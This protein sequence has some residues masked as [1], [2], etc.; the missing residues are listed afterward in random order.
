MEL[1]KSENLA[2]NG[3]KIL[4]GKSILL[5]ITGSIAAYKA[6][7][8]IRLLEGLGA[9]IT[10]VMTESAQKFITPL[11][12]KVISRNPVYH[13][14]FN[15]DREI[16]HLSLSERNNLILIAPATA[17]IIAKIAHG[18]ADDLLSSLILASKKE[19]IIAPAMDSEMWENPIMCRN[20]SILKETG[21]KVIPPGR[22]ELAS[23]KKGMGRLAEEERIVRTVT[24]T[25]LVRDNLKGKLVLI[26]AGPT[27]EPIDPVRFISSRSSGKMGYAL[28]EAA[29][30]RGAEVILITGP[31]AISPPEGTKTI[32]IRKAEEMREKVRRHLSEANI[33]I[34]A[35]AVSDYRPVEEVSHKIK[36]ERDEIDLRLKKTPDILKEITRE[37][38][39]QIV[40]GFAAET[41]NLM[42]NA[43]SKLKEKDLDIIVANDVT[44]EGSG[45][46]SNTN[47]VKIIDRDGRVTNLQKMSK[48]KI[49]DKIMDMIIRM[50]V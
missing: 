41:D 28:A 20:I 29:R 9:E 14:M 39:R 10:V 2:G 15:T 6:V 36:K 24:D 48:I 34:M 26:T 37:K 21:I 4:K 22:G 31:V 45:F 49:A 42:K 23:G 18:I 33:V 43:L 5:G 17:N 50:S 47:I 7:N 8:I 27:Q 19:I 30:N 25:L 38:G 35:A 32:K 11:T 40:V 44:I 46:G 12:L 1:E 3:G 13:S 16:N